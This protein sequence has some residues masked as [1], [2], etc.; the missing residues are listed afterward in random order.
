MVSFFL[1]SL[2]MVFDILMSKWARTEKVS[3]NYICS[4]YGVDIVFI[5]NLL[6]VDDL[7]LIWSKALWIWSRYGVD[8]EF[9]WS[10]CGVY[11]E[12]M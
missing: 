2:T 12:F 8:M 9:I 6:K 5:W 7:E 10:L 4:G 3:L 1:M 11:V